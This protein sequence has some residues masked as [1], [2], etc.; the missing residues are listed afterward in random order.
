MTIQNVDDYVRE[1]DRQAAILQSAIDSANAA[2]T[3]KTEFLSRMSHDIRTP[4]NSIM[5]MLDLAKA[6]CDDK[7]KVEKCLDKIT[8]SSQMLLNLINDI[9]DLSKIESNTVKL[10]EETLS[11]QE[12]FNDLENMLMPQI[13]SKEHNFNID[14]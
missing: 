2:N 4:M 7:E 6:Y 12:I 11:L 14:L 8:V 5:G 1:K 9:L 13:L 10:F 3:A